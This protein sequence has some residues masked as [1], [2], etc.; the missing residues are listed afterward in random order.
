MRDTECDGA[1]LIRVC[2]QVLEDSRA[3]LIAA[4]MQP[5]DP[6]PL[7]DKIKEGERLL[8]FHRSFHISV[9]ACVRVC[10][11]VCVCVCFSK[12]VYKNYLNVLIEL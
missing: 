11:C 8:L 3:F 7:D 4:N 12:C 1:D 2:V 5:D 10:V 9:R 6:F